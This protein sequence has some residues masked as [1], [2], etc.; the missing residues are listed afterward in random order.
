MEQEASQKKKN[1]IVLEPLDQGGITVL[2]Q[3]IEDCIRKS[4]GDDA[5]VV[6]NVSGQIRA[7]L[8]QPWAIWK[9]DLVVAMLITG[10]VRDGFTGKNATMVHGLHGH[11]ANDEWVDAAQQ[12]E[13]ILASMGYSQIVAWTF[14]PRVVELCNLFGWG[15]RTVCVKELTNG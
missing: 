11:L 1:S 15:T 13:A 10:P 2:W 3:D 14:N 6:A 5:V 12:L 4:I 9:E 7:R 8:L